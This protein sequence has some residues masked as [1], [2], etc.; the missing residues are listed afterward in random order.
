[1]MI[2]V[3]FGI[4]MMGSS[5]TADYSTYFMNLHIENTGIYSDL[6]KYIVKVHV[7]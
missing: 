4:V 3:T 1:M 2:F 6:Y 5:R 7:I